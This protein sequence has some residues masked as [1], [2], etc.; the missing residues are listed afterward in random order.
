MLF[1]DF[2]PWRHVIKQP[3]LGNEMDGESFLILK[4]WW[5][6]RGSNSRQPA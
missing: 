3:H 2:E 4:I 5:G 1:L 6:W